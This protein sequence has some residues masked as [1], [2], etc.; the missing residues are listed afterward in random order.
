MKWLKRFNESESWAG[1]VWANKNPLITTYV[2]AIEVKRKSVY[3]WKCN[4]C[5]IEFESFSKEESTCQHCK[6][7][8][9][10]DISDSNS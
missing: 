5:D 1:S 7:E 3:N 4:S 8:D 10:Y 2:N 9:I 6:S